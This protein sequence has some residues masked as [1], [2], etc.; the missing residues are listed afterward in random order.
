MTLNDEEQ[1]PGMFSDERALAEEFYA[2]VQAASATSER[3]LQAAAFKAGVSDLGFCSERTRRMIAQQVPASTDYL[4]AFIGT[5]IGDHVE[6]AYAATHPEVIVQPEVLVTLDGDGGSYEVTGHPDLVDPAGVVIDVKTKRGLSIVTRTGPNQQ[7]QFQRHLYAKGAYHAGLFHDDV[8]LADVRVANVW[9][10]RAA[11]DRYAHVHMEPYS[12]SMVTAATFWLDDVVYAYLNGQ[13]A[14]K[15]PAREVCEKWCGFYRDC[16]ML[17][18]DVEG[19]LSDPEVVTAVDLMV[20]ARELESKARKLKDTAKAALTGVT[21]S[22]GKY[23]VRW[24]HVNGGPVSYTRD[25]YE[26]LDV[27]PIK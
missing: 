24:I 17:D 7:Q 14:R 20:E 22:T 27:K 16:R 26:R 10:D 25:S 4:D 15:E 2:A 6:R 21:G 23:A 11:D 1:V 19:Y 3:S 18:T 5:A 13:E 12:E 9:F 8:A